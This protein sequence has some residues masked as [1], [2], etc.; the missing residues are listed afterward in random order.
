M[1]GRLSHSMVKQSDLIKAAIESNYLVQTEYN[2]VSFAHLESLAFSECAGAIVFF[3]WFHSCACD[4]QQSYSNF[5][6]R[7]PTLAKTMFSNSLVNNHTQC[8]E[9]WEEAKEAPTKRSIISG[10]RS[11]TTGPTGASTG[12]N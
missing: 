7:V 3:E 5:S 2:H 6:Q 11:S 8:C 1:L 4:E 9:K 10:N 12:G